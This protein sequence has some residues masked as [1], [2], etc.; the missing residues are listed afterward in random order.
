M[1]REHKR[2]LLGELIGLVHQGRHGGLSGLLR[3]VQALGTRYELQGCRFGRP[4]QVQRRQDAH[5]RDRIQEALHLR[6][7]GDHEC[8]VV[9]CDVRHREVAECWHVKP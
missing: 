4:A 9:R 3:G 8:A 1:H 7:V 2:L 6:P 5:A